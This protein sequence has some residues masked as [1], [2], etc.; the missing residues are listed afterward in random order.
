M[1]DELFKITAISSKT[2]KIILI[3]KIN[4]KYYKFVMTFK[5]LYPQKKKN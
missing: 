5:K 1:I 3:Y 2:D 4:I